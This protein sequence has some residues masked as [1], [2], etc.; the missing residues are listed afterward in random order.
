ME[1]IFKKVFIKNLEWSEGDPLIESKFYK[2]FKSKIAEIKP[3]DD[4]KFEIA[5]FEMATDYF[6]YEFYRG[7]NHGLVHLEKDTIENNIEEYFEWDKIKQLAEYFGII[8]SKHKF[9]ENDETFV[10]SKEK[11]EFNRVKKLLSTI[12]S[13][14]FLVQIERIKVFLKYGIEKEFWYN[15]YEIELLDESE[16]EDID[17]IVNELTR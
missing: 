6:I 13:T 3:E 10:F 4:S 15:L 11:I 12:I 16:K 5:A 2:T 14:I 8:E 9:S 1:G 17:Q 7:S